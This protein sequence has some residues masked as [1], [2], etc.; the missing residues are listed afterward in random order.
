MHRV[1]RGKNIAR[2]STVVRVAQGWAADFGKVGQVMC[3]HENCHLT[4]RR[5]ALD[6]PRLVLLG[7]TL[8]SWRIGLTSVFNFK[9]PAPFLVL[10][11]LRLHFVAGPL[12]MSRP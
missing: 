1:E 4:E 10:L 8:Q 6:S 3:F 9:V 11:R 7:S 12:L 2:T 5:S